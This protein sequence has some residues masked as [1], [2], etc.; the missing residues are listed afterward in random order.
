MKAVLLA[1]GEGTRLRPITNSIPKCL[2][3]IR[4]QPLLG[5]WLELCRDSDI[6]EVLINFH[7]HGD[8]V[9]QFVSER[10]YGV[11]VSWFEEPVLLGS[12]GTIAVNRAWLESEPCFFVFY[13]D[14]LTNMD[15][16]AMLDFHR[17][18]GLAATLGLY[19]VPNPSQCGIVEVDEHNIVRAFREKPAQPA[20]RLAFSGVMIG[21]PEFL[22]A[23]PAG[24]PADLGFDVFPRLIGR[25]A[26]YRSR[27]YL[28][29]IGTMSNYE[30]AQRGWPGLRSRLEHSHV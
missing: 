7:A 25:M 29:D 10:D 8:A 3:P 26:G 28:L 1:A 19:E 9:R 14:V 4:Q 15:L 11:R 6:G 5:I 18:A 23:I 24:A 12:A 22:Q 17:R 13:A 2:V 16:S 21:T 30:A 27:E 20:G